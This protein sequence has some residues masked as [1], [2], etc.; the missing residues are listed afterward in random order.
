MMTLAGWRPRC[1][2][3]STAG[4]IGPWVYETYQVAGLSLISTSITGLSLVLLFFLCAIVRRK[5]NKAK[6]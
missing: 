6:T 3:S 4:F 1:S 5:N 2:G